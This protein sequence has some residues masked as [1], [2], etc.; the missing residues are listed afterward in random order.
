MGRL[1]LGE[2]TIRV[3]LL[4]HAFWRTLS[5]MTV[6]VPI[7]VF[8]A[9][10][11]LWWAWKTTTSQDVNNLFSISSKAFFLICC[12][13]REF[14]SC[15]FPSKAL[16]CLILLVTHTHTHTSSIHIYTHAYNPVPYI[17][18]KI[19]KTIHGISN[20]TNSEKQIH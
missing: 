20:N 17:F 10:V 8:L 9:W 7:I 13:Q 3:I 18:T 6:L 2:I 19:V 5:T 4:V 16:A 12:Y 1:T 14:L 15:R 11:L